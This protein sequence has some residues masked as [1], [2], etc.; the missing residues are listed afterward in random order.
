MLT[1][2]A[3]GK[4]TQI[5]YSEQYHVQKDLHPDTASRPTTG[6]CRSS[7]PAKQ[8]EG[9]TARASVS[10]A[11]VAADLRHRLRDASDAGQQTL[12]VLRCKHAHQASCCT[13]DFLEL[14]RLEQADGT[15]M[16][17]PQQ[18]CESL[19]FCSFCTLILCLL[20]QLTA[21]S[22]TCGEPC[23]KAEVTHQSPLWVSLAF[24][25]QTGCEG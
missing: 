4:A 25:K 14:T 6:V 9:P 10:D 12:L 24:R 20:L 15:R 3:A 11:G 2:F 18:P 22:F 8:T 13:S 16:Q 17:K 1:F 7:M 23:A 19:G 5:R 21:T